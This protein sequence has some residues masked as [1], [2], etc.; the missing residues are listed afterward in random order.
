MDGRINECRDIWMN[1]Y[2]SINSHLI[3]LFS[4]L[5][6]QSIIHHSI[7]DAILGALTLPD[8]GELFPGKNPLEVCEH[9]NSI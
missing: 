8:I 9:D 7:V 2:V 3:H 1:V 4:A 6:R 5:L